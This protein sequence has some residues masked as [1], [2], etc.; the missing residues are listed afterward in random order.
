MKKQ[1]LDRAALDR[2]EGR[3]ARIKTQIG[4]YIMILPS[5]LM[6][7]LFNYVPMAGIYVAFT[8]YKPAK[9][10]FGGK[11]VGFK[12]FKLF[13]EGMD[14]ERVLRNTLL[15]SIA[16]IILISLL[17]G[18]IFALL[19]Y[20]IKSKMANKVYH[21]CMLLPAFISWTVT[22][23]AL[24]VLLHADKGMLNS[25]I[26]KLGGEPVAWYKEAQHWPLIIMLCQIYKN[27]GM[28]S[29]YFY[30]SL[31]SI[32]TELFDAAQLDG[33]NRVQQIWHISLPAMAKIFCIT[34]IMSMGGVLSSALS[35]YFELTF[36]QGALYETTQVLGTY[37]YN[38][39][40][41]GRFSFMA[42]VGL[43]Q[44]VI[45]LVLVLGSNFIVKKVDSE[46]AMF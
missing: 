5:V 21:T 18:V 45:G 24:L 29:I 15:Y 9:G 28:S 3:L 41:G 8:D 17:V 11:F 12:H 26:V 32:D 16:N 14:F 44:S 42:A 4:Y 2:R 36:N 20:E 7:L 1:V 34:L 13:I 25:L 31:L 19:L 30:S 23:A 33:A 27:A 40:G 43:M 35:P 10:M 38:G 39:I 37:I 46:S 6:L 22:S